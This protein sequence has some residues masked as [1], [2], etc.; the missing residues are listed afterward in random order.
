MDSIF[1]RLALLLLLACSSTAA[2]MPQDAAGGLSVLAYALPWTSHT[3]DI[4]RIGVEMVNRNHTYTAVLGSHL[5]QRAEDYLK[6]HFGSDHVPDKMQARGGAAG[7][8]GRSRLPPRVSPANS[9]ATGPQVVYYQG[10]RP[11]EWQQDMAEASPLKAI[12]AVIQARPSGTWNA[13][14]W[15]AGGCSGRPRRRTSARPPDAA[16]PAPVLL[17][18]EPPPPALPCRRPSSPTARS[19]STTRS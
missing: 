5:Q 7:A 1:G 9:S 12:E 6:H 14:C 15:H 18:S 10:I 2:Q 3:F 17:S 8:A 19:S 16:A 11:E 13:P 4:L